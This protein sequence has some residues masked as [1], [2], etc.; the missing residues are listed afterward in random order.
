MVEETQPKEKKEKKEKPPAI[1]DKP[2]T[3][4]IEQHFVPT[5]K[6]SLNK[7]GLTDIELSFTQAPISIIGA[8]TNKPC[9]QIIGT[10]SNGQRKFII[11]FPEESISGQKAFSYGH[12]NKFF[13]TLE[14]FMIDERKVTLDL[15]ILYTLQR[16][17]RQK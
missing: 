5:L 16:I 3:E 13:S 8:S 9:S 14:S 6:E 7:K 4:F 12:N 17:T 1:E 11:Y 15:L 10:W 2:F